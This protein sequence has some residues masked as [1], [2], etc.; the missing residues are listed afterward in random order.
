MMQLL[1]IVHGVCLIALLDWE[2]THNFVDTEVEL[3][4]FGKLVI[5]KAKD[6]MESIAD[7]GDS[8]AWC[9]L[10]LLV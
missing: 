4:L 7:D 8:I 1:I 10:L 3:G 6:E 9:G 5:E 2:S